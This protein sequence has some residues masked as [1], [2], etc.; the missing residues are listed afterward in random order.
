MGQ[1]CQNPSK[2]DK[3]NRSANFPGLSKFNGASEGPQN[4]GKMTG[5]DLPE[6]IDINGADPK[7]GRSGAMGEIP[8]HLLFRVNVQKSIFF[9]FFFSSIL[10]QSKWS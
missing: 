8:P 2:H 5:M 1:K 3:K 4:G 10:W 9:I 7:P 6:F